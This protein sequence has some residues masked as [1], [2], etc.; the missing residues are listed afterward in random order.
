MD[1]NHAD[2]NKLAVKQRLV[3]KVLRHLIIVLIMLFYGC[4]KDSEPVPVDCDLSDLGIEATGQNPTGCSANDGSITASATG[5]TE[6]YKFA[7][8]TGAFGTSPVF[9]NLGGG[10]YVVLVKDK[11]ECVR[12]VEVLLQLPG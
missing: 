12:S 1:F 5:G 3:T 11:N 10:N 2:Q 7:I 9:N 4:A 6:P 8:N